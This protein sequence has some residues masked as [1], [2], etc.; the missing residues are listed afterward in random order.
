MEKEDIERIR[1]A[2]ARHETPPLRIALLFGSLAEGRA[3]PDSDL[4]VA[5]AADRPLDAAQKQ[6]LIEHLAEA[7]GRPVD[8]I[9]LRIV[10]EPLLGRALQGRPLLMR[11]RR[12]FEEIIKRHL[13]ETEDFLPLQRRLLAER[14][15]AWTGT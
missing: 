5:V 3:R 1:D 7:S 14:R 6:S 15:K 9:D 2:L 8:L 13:I 4:D 10:G 11:D 12:L